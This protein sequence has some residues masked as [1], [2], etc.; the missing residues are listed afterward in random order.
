MLY[1]RSSQH[2]ALALWL[3]ACVAK[4]GW[5]WEH[6]FE[7]DSGAYYINLV[8]GDVPPSA[9][10]HASLIL[11]SCLMPRAYLM[12][13]SSLMPHACLITQAQRMPHSCARYACCIRFAYVA[14]TCPLC[15]S[16]WGC[17]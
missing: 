3:A 1:V 10:T 7:V 6:K 2:P 8:S 17:S 16:A 5:I 11:R 13:A 12:Y 9:I 4:G 15:C 14:F